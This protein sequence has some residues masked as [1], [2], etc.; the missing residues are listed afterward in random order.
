MAAICSAAPPCVRLRLNCALLAAPPNLV[1]TC[2]HLSVCFGP[3][4]KPCLPSVLHVSASWPAVGQDRGIMKYSQ[5]CATR[6]VYIACLLVSFLG[7]HF[8]SQ[9]RPLQAHLMLEKRFRVF[10]LFSYNSVC[11]HFYWSGET[12]LC[13]LFSWLAVLWA[14]AGALCSW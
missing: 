7:I 10:G 12:T 9:I 1:R 8:G 2:P 3:A 4:S 14:F 11:S 6:R 13:R 5:H